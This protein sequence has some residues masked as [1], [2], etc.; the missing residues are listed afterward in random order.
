MPNLDILLRAVDQ[1]SPALNKVAG[2]VERLESS[3]GRG[4]KVLGGLKS[5][6]GTGLKIAGGA[7]AIG[8]GAVGFALRDS[9]SLAREQINVEKQLEAVLKS[10]GGAAGLTADE[11]KKMASELQGVTNFGDEA[12]LAGQNMLLT[13]TN[14]GKDVFPQATETMLNMSQAMGQ[15]IKS[16][17]IQLGKALNDPIAGIGAL[18]RVGIQFTDQQK[19]MIAAMM[20]AGDVAG[21]Q[22]IILGELETQFGGSA[23]A[24]AEP[25]IQLQNVWGDMKEEIGKAVIPLLANLAQ[26]LL[27]HVQKATEWLAGAVGEFTK[28]LDEGQGPLDALM[29]A[30]EVFLPKKTLDRIQK[31]IDFGG[32]VASF[33]GGMKRDFDETGTS[34]NGIVGGIT[35]FFKEHFGFVIDWWNDNLPLMKETADVIIGAIVKLFSGEG[36]GELGAIIELVKTT[37]GVL[38][39]ITKF[40]LGLL[41][42]IIT[43]IMQLITGDFEGA[44]ETIKMIWQN[45]LSLL[46]TTAQNMLPAIINA[47]SAI[48]TGIANAFRNIDW[49]GVGRAILEGVAAGISAAGSLIIDAA[50]RAARSAYDAAKRALGIGSPSK[51]AEEG[52][53]KPFA[54]GIAVGIGQELNALQRRVSAGV[55]GMTSA[56][57]P[58]PVAMAASSGGGTYNISVN[59]SGGDYS[60][61]RQ[62]G[63][64]IL[65]E[66]R[67]RGLR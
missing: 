39:E 67:A 5:A 18:S 53:G 22:A 4:S 26:R 51:L 41:L 35:D 59:L 50:K 55:V 36:S 61:G 27:P 12:T 25:A 19:D 21:A 56:M 62:V 9:L 3:A 47:V 8:L 49:A 66:L 6:L 7:A 34:V 52:I 58:Q 33:L 30:L 24:M 40:S 32:K 15:D 13:F 44:G 17:A 45:F 54:Q 43:L 57:G 29:G 46:V 31:L 16:S 28:R 11:I 23:R 37:L 60:T 1:A 2:G 20:E 42:N 65:D 10:T 63:R 64:G 14:I 38:L 48:A